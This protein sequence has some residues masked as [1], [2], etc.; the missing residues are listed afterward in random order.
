MQFGVV[1]AEIEISAF[2]HEGLMLL[3]VVM[4]LGV[5]YRMAMGQY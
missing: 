1:A 3:L 2:D 4:L 5:I